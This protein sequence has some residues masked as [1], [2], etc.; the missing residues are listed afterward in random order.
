MND[1]IEL[2]RDE[3]TATIWLNRPARGNT[4]TPAMLVALERRLAEV[5]AD[6]SLRCLIVRG[7]GPNFCTGMDL[8]SLQGGPA[9]MSAAARHAAAVFDRLNALPL[10]TVCGVQGYCTGAGFELMLAADLVVATT[11]AR[12]GEMSIKVGLFG[13]AGPSYH[14]PRIVGVRRTK[15]LLMTGRMLDAAE[16]ASWGLVNTTV[17]EPGLEAALA[18]LASTFLDKPPRQ[19]AMTKAVA[20]AGLDADSRSLRLVERLAFDLAVSG[21]DAPEGIAAFRE[22]RPPQWRPRGD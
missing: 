12:I 9:G 15:E 1:E 16:A 4:L 22:K 17:D 19:L 6:N 20:A 21:A 10:P 18:R 13:G 8:A 14:L 5:E 11:E 2:T 3:A 7:R